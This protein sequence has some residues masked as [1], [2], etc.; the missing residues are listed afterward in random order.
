[1]RVLAVSNL[2][3]VNYHGGPSMVR[4]R[5]RCRQLRRGA[6]DAEAVLWRLLRNRQ[7]AGRKFRR[8]HAFG[9]YILDFYCPER[10]LAVETDGGQHFDPE[11][12]DHDRKRTEY[13]AARGIRV[14]RFTNA[15]VLT[16]PEAVVEVIWRE[17]VD[18]GGA[19]SP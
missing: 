8:Q 11:Q 3:K 12:A 18:S 9:A 7:I 4:L 15:E 6:T 1:V 17:A 13:L 5:E 2:I 19:P 16:N 10:R 14:L